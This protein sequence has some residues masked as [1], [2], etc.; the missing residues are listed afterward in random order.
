MLLAFLLDLVGASRS[1]AAGNELLF[2]LADGSALHVTAAAFDREQVAPTVAMIDSFP[3]GS[4]LTNLDL[5]VGRSVEVEN[6][7]GEE[8]MACY[9]PRAEEMVVDGEPGLVEAE[10]LISVVAHEYGHHIANNREGGIWPAFD[11]GTLRWSTYE[12]V[13]ERTRKG[14]LY[15]G[16]EGSHYWENPGEAFAQSYATLVE[17]A[18]PWPYT[19]L[20]APDPTALRKIREDVRDPVRPRMSIWQ[21]GSPKDDG[22]AIADA[23]PVDDASFH[24]VV[25][26]PYDGRIGI[27]LQG[28]EAGRYR[29]I[30]SD[31]STG[32]VLTEAPPTSG[33][34]TSVV[35]AD[36]GH[37]AVEVTA[38][39]IGTSPGFRAEIS[40][41]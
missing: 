17:P 22:P 1:S 13:C 32:E 5:E 21:V 16:N 12:Q 11:Q 34:K 38:E 24:R 40:T 31:P 28:L 15:P 3:H 37:R 25:A 8:T 27:R 20:L 35:Y 39:A 19:P 4:E 33:G 41:P 26:M 30:V 36:C 9:D 23:L 6:R 18:T 14:L 2:R 10:P 7:C 29:I